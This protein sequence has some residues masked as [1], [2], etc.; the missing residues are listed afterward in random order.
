MTDLGKRLYFPKGNVL[1]QAAQAKEAGCPFNAT[2][3]ELK[4]EDGA[5]L[6]LPSM[7]TMVG[8]SAEKV[9]LYQAQG[10]RRDL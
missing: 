10:G 7:Q 4:G 6:P 1:S 3:G 8:L 9:F 2:I 5:A